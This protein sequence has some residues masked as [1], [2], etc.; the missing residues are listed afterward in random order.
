MEQENYL[1]QLLAP[2]KRFPDPA[3]HVRGVLTPAPEMSPGTVRITKGIYVSGGVKS[4]TDVVVMMEH[5]SGIKTVTRISESYSGPVDI[6]LEVIKKPA[7][8]YYF[9]AP[10]F[11][12]WLSQ[13]TLTP[14]GIRHKAVRIAN[15]FRDGYGKVI[16]RGENRLYPTVS[17]SL[18]REWCT[19]SPEALRT[20]GQHQVNS[21]KNGRGGLIGR[22]KALEIQVAIQ[23]LGGK[24]NLLD[25]SKLPWVALYFACTG[26][27]AAAETGR[28]LRLDISKPRYDFKVHHDFTGENYP[29]ARERLENQLGVLVEPRTGVLGARN[30]KTLVTIQPDEKLLFRDLLKKIDIEHKTLFA[31]LVAYVQ[32]WHGRIPTNAWMYIMA[33]RLRAG[34]VDN[35][36]KLADLLVSEDRESQAGL[37]YRGLARVLLGDLV[38]ARV[39]F[40]E[41]IEIFPGPVPKVLERNHALVVKAIDSDYPERARRNLDLK[42]DENI[43]VMTLKGYTYLK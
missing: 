11:V 40:E 18:S 1:Y 2:V 32:E 37:Y 29:V 42:V 31:D 5:I 26:E 6:T 7:E 15:S 35:V 28:L 30:L 22:M 41:L 39:D 38:N 16:Y 17:S 34:Q 3:A 13:S 25:F 21:L 8:L 9:T 19:K 14:D 24:T 4:W 43:G 36:R 12:E 33:E 20:I 10:W 23:H 27:N